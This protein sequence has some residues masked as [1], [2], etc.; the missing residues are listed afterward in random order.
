MWT[1]STAKSL[2]RRLNHSG[3]CIRCASSQPIPARTRFAPSPTGNLHL[4]SL[5]TAL[6]NYLW[7]RKTGGQF[8]VRVEDTD[9]KRLYPGAEASLFENLAWAGLHPDESPM[10]EGRHAPYRQSDRLDI[11]KQHIQTLLDNQSVYRCFCPAERLSA[12]RARGS[13]TGFSGTYDR[14]CAHVSA[15]ESAQRAADGEQHVIRLHSPDAYPAVT[16]IVHGTVQFHRSSKKDLVSNINFDDPVLIKS[17]GYPTYHFANVVDDHLMQITHVIRGEEWLPSTPKHL[18]LY[19]AFGWQAPEFAHVPLLASASGAKLSKRHGDVSVKDYRKRGYLPE[20]LLNYLALMGWNAHQDGEKSDVLTLDEMVDRFELSSITKGAAVV[21]ADKLHYL[22]KQHYIR[23]SED[24]DR[25]QLLIDQA[26]SILHEAY[27]DDSFSDAYVGQ[28]IDVLKERMVDPLGLPKL[29]QYFFTEPHYASMEAIKFGKK[30]ARTQIVPL[31]EVLRAA[32]QKLDSISASGWTE[33]GFDNKID[34]L[35]KETGWQ[36]ENGQ[37]L[38]ALRY[39][40]ADGLSGAGVKQ[41][42]QIIG[43]KRTLERIAAAIATCR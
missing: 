20:S 7:A 24:S 29:G 40:L 19:E 6:Y 28:V 14:K 34:A 41:I 23:A 35:L 39:A 42:M 32:E 18:S 25:R 43:R 3:Y 13:K 9:Q 37:V 33:A 31:K 36:V 15:A 5:R 17:D 12:L 26:Q 8:L 16:D 27:P 1:G 38:G 10:H 21:T 11:Y 2:V 4:G 30:F 22:Q